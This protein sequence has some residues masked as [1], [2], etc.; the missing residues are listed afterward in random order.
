ML[1]AS[2]FFHALKPY[3]LLARLDKPI[4]TVL[5]L[6]PCWWGVAYIQ[7]GQF[8][9]SLLALFSV[10]ALVM[11]SAG[12]ILN[13]LFDQDVDRQVKRTKDRP[14]AAGTA[15]R[16]PAFIFF[17]ILC[18][19]GLV[20][21]LQLPQPCWL[22]GVVGLLLLF[23]YPS[24]KRLTNFPQACLGFAFNIGFLMGIVAATGK[25]NSL[26]SIPVLL[27]YFA[28]ILW[29]IGYDT[30]YAVQDRGDDIRLGVRS[31]AV[32]FGQHVRVV[33]LG[34]YIASG[35]L[36]LWAA[37][38]QSMPLVADGLILGTYMWISYRLWRLDLEDVSACRDF[39]IANQW[40]GSA[41]FLALII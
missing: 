10:G 18:F 19:L 14:L 29:T 39:F 13:D 33:T 1:Y 2:R 21:L 22:I 41:I 36:M 24:M 3:F 38:L 20:V 26:L 25:I 23:I 31:T 4:G 5:L 7:K 34:I 40:V 37:I 30:V 32:F 9:L 35:G 15:Q 28:A 27:I 8:S 6:F 12:C 17:L 16:L 11:R